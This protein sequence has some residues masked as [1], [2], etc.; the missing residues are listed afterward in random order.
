MTAAVPEEIV[1]SLCV[2]FTTLG[3]KQSLVLEEYICQENNW[4]HFVG[5]KLLILSISSSEGWGQKEKNS[6]FKKLLTKEDE[7][8]Q[9]YC[10]APGR[11]L[12][13][14]S[15]GPDEIGAHWTFMART[16]QIGAQ[17][18]LIKLE[19]HTGFDNTVVAATAMNM[20]ELFSYVL[21]GAPP[22]QHMHAYIYMAA[23][24]V[25]L[26]CH[27]GSKNSF[28]GISAAR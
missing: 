19:L 28:A 18:L 3:L 16:I 21:G 4:F 9:S 25:R 10:H 14:T 17:H 24:E 6:C 7:I 26:L 23:N 13:E 2:I 5:L 8:R 12:A 27:T 1:E 22:V 11:P 15:T 20:K